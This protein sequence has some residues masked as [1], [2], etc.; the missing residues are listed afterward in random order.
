MINLLPACDAKFVGTRGGE[1][2]LTSA[3]RK[4]SFAVGTIHRL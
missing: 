1:K 3:A 2:C 4:C